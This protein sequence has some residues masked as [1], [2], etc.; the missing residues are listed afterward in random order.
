[1]EK[2]MKMGF[3][4]QNTET[5]TLNKYAKIL[6]K[7]RIQ[8][9][10]YF[11]KSQNPI[12]FHMEAI[13]MA[14]F[15]HKLIPTDKKLVFLCVGSNTVYADG[16]GPCI[17]SMLGKICNTMEIYGN[18][19]QNIDASN[20]TDYVELIYTKHKNDFVLAVDASIS[21]TRDPG[22]IVVTNQPL[23]PGSA[24][25]NGGLALMGNATI[26]GIMAPNYAALKNVTSQQAF[27]KEM[28]NFVVKAIQYYVCFF[29]REA[30]LNVDFTE[31][32]NLLKQKKMDNGS[33]RNEK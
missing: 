9:R 1:M 31:E 11:G 12:L 5:A 19:H 32:R 22:T 8:K 16:F 20:M 28:Q 4:K 2:E 17:G 6:K 14:R 18:I 27:V 24:I 25:S 29:R 33:I 7:K 23:C 21:K 26:K 15:L 10:Y 13:C 30:L 3:F